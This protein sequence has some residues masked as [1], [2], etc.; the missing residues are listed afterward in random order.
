LNHAYGGAAAAL[1][2]DPN[3][4]VLIPDNTFPFL[5]IVNYIKH[6]L[7]ITKWWACFWSDGSITKV[8]APTRGNRTYAKNRQKRIDLAIENMLDQTVP[9][10]TLWITLTKRY[11]KTEDGRLES[12]NFFPKM[13]P[14]FLR[15]LR[16]LG[17]IKFIH[18]KEAHYDGGCHVHILAKWNVYLPHRVEYKKIKNSNEY[19]EVWRLDNWHLKSKIVKSWGFGRIEI[20]VVR[21]KQIGNY[22]RKEVGKGSNIE[23]SLRRAERNWSKEGDL[24][25]KDRDVKKIYALYYAS[26]LKIRM[27]TTSRNLPA[28]EELSAEEE[29]SCLLTGKNNTTDK[30]NDSNKKVLEEVIEIPP[31]L[32]IFFKFD[33]YTGLV[34]ADT[35]LYYELMRL[36]YK[37]PPEG[38]EFLNL[39]ENL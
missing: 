27:I 30:N 18:V 36:R 29:S 14:R 12:W 32:K 26:L 9:G 15:K 23:P 3:A 10:T 37:P 39:E 11:K 21:S 6:S 31:Y 4:K 34:D 5:K 33:V 24:N 35:E 17:M 38:T 19:R 2:I 1:A 20:Q 25:Y 16:S 13:L 28:I 8:P 22:L 7:Y